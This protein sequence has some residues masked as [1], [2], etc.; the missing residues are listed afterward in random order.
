[1]AF[2]WNWGDLLTGAIGVGL[3]WLARLPQQLSKKE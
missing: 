2:D 3:G 1:M